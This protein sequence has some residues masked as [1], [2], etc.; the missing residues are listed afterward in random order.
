MPTT[1]P[2]GLV[3]YTSPDELTPLETAFNTLTAS[4]SGALD[5]NVR[6][7]KVANAAA[8][9]ALA[10]Q[11]TPSKENPL[12][13]WRVDKKYFEINDGSGWKSISSDSTKEIINGTAYNKS[14]SIQATISSW[15]RLGTSTYEWTGYTTVAL[16]YTPPEGWTFRV[17]VTASPSE[18]FVFSAWKRT[19]DFILR[20]RYY[21]WAQ[22]TS[23]TFTLGWELIKA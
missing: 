19:S 5:E 1:D 16:P 21:L 23:K 18:D 14:G 11:R 6:T 22:A 8:R 4:I 7:F 9:D 17:T 3:L 13:V 20:C 12:Q 15:T 2:N 10:T